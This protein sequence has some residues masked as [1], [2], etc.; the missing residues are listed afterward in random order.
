[1]DKRSSTDN[2]KITDGHMSGKLGRI[3]HND[4]LTNAAIMRNM[5]VSHNQCAA[6]DAGDPIMCTGVGIG[7]MQGG[8]VDGRELTDDRVIAQFDISLFCAFELQILW[9][10]GN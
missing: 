2:G 10:V 9:D 7:I 1:M 3:R 6:S 4:A 8:T 5:G